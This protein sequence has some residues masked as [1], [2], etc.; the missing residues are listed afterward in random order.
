[1]IDSDFR[2]EARVRLM[3]FVTI[4][5]HG[6]WLFDGSTSGTGRGGGYGRLR[7]RGQY[8][9]A[10]RLS[11]LAFKGPLLPGRHVG[12]C[13]PGRNPP[14]RRCINPAHIDQMSPR[15]NQRQRVRDM[16]ARGLLS[17]APVCEAA[18]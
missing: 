8:W 3:G 12:H 2:R 9:A 13:C 4:D 16:K 7:F 1:M 17:R 5:E 18:P 11:H 14:D 15:R 6:C 10:H